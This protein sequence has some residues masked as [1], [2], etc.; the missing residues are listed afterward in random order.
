MIENLHP[1]LIGGGLIIV[2]LLGSKIADRLGLPALLM[3]LGVG[4]LAGSDGIGKIYFDNPTLVNRIGVIALAF[5]IFAGGLDTSWRAIRPILFR[6]NLLSSVG[7]LL[8]ALFT[9]L[10]AWKV[11]GFPLDV[12]ALLGVIMSS[13]DAAA[14]FSILRSRGVSLRGKLRPLLEFE[15]GSNDPMAVFMTLLVMEWIKNPHLSFWSLIPSFIVQ[16]GLGTLLGL[17]LGRGAAWLLNRF[18]LD[19]EGL[20]PVLSMSIVLVV[21]GLTES[22]KGNGFMA[23]Y[24]AGIV[25][26]N[27]SFYYKRRLCKFHDGISWLM[28][29]IMFLILGLQV[30]PSQLIGFSDEGLMLALFLMFASRP[31]AGFICLLGSKFNWREQLL[32]NWVGLRGAAPI[33]LATFPLTSNHPEASTIF[34]V[35]FF[36]VLMSVL[37]QGKTLMPMARWLKVDEVLQHRP[38]CP[39]EFEN[40]PGVQNE[41]IEIDILPGSPVIGQKISQITLAEGVLILMVRKDKEFVIPKGKTVLEENDTVLLMGHRDNIFDAAKTFNS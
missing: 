29:I 38:P 5:I 32:I 6:G 1:F 26:G 21:F 23:V 17:V 30:F 16:M 36:I 15:S 28:Q 41:A 40:T 31:L 20:Y 3:F 2:C 33:I 18:K 25:L 22:V 39:L 4:M 19:Y 11:L 35:V 12:S 27:H 10:F 34:N 24:L 9:A 13:T 7:V 14:V 8:T 37:I